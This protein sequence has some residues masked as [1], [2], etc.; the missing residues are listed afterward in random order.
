MYSPLPSAGG[1][2]QQPDSFQDGEGASS[3]VPI[4]SLDPSQ[5]GFDSCHSTISHVT[6][7]F[8]LW[9]ANLCMHSMREQVPVQFFACLV[10][11]GHPYK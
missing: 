10:L 5:K 4:F 2:A 7:L 1:N 11:V 3:V 6:F 9:Q 8:E